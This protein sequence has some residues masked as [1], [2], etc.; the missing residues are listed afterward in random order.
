MLA[1]LDG[2]S[3]NEKKHGDD[4]QENPTRENQERYVIARTT[5]TPDDGGESR[6]GRTNKKRP[7]GGSPGERSGSAERSVKGKIRPRPQA[8]SGAVSNTERSWLALRR[9]LH[10]GYRDFEE[11]G[12]AEQTAAE[13]RRGSGSRGAGWGGEL[14]TPGL[15]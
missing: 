15:R 11:T 3:G 7:P 9:A 12:V 14:L 10:E 5:T 8:R 1:A 6:D 4:G 13:A 2:F